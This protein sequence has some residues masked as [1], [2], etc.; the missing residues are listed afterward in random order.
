MAANRTR[1]A[2]RLGTRSRQTLSAGAGTLLGNATGVLL[3]FLI[4]LQYGSGR[5]TDGY[6]LATASASFVV[7]L[8]AAT[9]S[10]SVIWFARLRADESAGPEQAAAITAG[11]L[12][13]SV[14]A[15]VG[16]LVPVYLATAIVIVPNG[17]FSENSERDVLLLLL[18][19]LP[20]PVAAAASS[21][22][23]AA[24]YAYGRFALAT[25]TTGLRSL[26]ALLCA[27]G[28]RADLPLPVVAG[29]LT[30]GELVRFAVLR[31]YAPCPQPGL[32]QLG[33]P[34]PLSG[35]WNLA[36]P[37]V[38]GMAIIGINPLVDKAVAAGIGASSI[39]TLELAEKLF[40][41][42]T[43]LFGGMIASVLASEWA[44]VHARTGSRRAVGVGYWQASRVILGA[45]SA[46]AG[47]GVVVVLLLGPP[48]GRVLGI[49]DGDRFALVLAVYLIGLPAA[50]YVEVSGRLITTLGVNRILPWLA[51][52]ALVVNVVLDL[53]GR[54]LF[55]LVGIA[56]A[57]T[58]IRVG[59]GLTMAWWL[60]RTFAQEAA[61]EVAPASRPV[62]ERTTDA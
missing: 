32:R 46:V 47:L 52:S 13:R 51:G 38:L 21:V 10:V 9:E 26:A 29:A 24:H 18:V 36:V 16:L 37:S 14:L 34:A 3:P 62:G 49:G 17:G 48:A 50:F 42:P 8:T 33:R 31:R 40:Y 27:L 58:I 30:L 53:I 1:R 19:L 4:V 43:I 20:L 22:L 39:T 61:S 57:T 55:G 28:G 6:F 7:L 44:G 11:L 41:V 5:I 35:Y 59:S 2:R 12:R 15:S 60:R 56:M 23:A 54:A 45:A 25:S